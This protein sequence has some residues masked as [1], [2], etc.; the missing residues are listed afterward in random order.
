MKPVSELRQDLVSGDWVVIATGRARRPREFSKEKRSAFVQPKSSC[1]FETLHKNVLVVYSLDGEYQ[2][3][4]RKVGT[5]AFS[6]KVSYGASGENWWVEVVPNKYPAFGR[7][8]CQIVRRAGLYSLSDSVGFHEVVVTRDHERSIALMNQEEVELVL[9]SYQD[10]FLALKDESCV[11]Y[12]SVFHNHGREAGAT[13]TH[14]HSQI[15]AIPVIPPDVARSLKGSA[16][17]LHTYQLCVHCRILAY[18]LKVGDRIIY[19]NKRFAV[20]A[21]FASKTA[22][23]IRVYPK[24]HE[25]RFENISPEDRFLLA[26]ALRTALAKLFE[27]LSNPDY[28]FFLHTAPVRNSKEFNHYHWHI[29]ILPKT[30]IWAGFEIGTGIEISTIAPEKAAAFLRKIKI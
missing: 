25:A 18:E 6:S 17:Y 28:N 2:K 12:I 13:L 23:E 24:Y 16:Q 15:I 8:R 27:G 21:P 26:D 10:R 9:R 5:P 1:P 7:G 14:P 22:F 4:R 20:L 29:E 30:A 19:Q 3:S 11:E